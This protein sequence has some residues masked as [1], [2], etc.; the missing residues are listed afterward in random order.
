MEGREGTRRA[1]VLIDGEHHPSAVADALRLVERDFSIVALTFCGGGEKVPASVL[2]D[3]AAH[4]GYEL[5]RGENPSSA[6]A[7]AIASADADCVV[8]L[9][10]EP[11]VTADVKL[12]LAS[13]AEAAGLEYLAPGMG[14]PSAPTESV[15]FDGAQIAVIGTGKRTGKTAVCGHL[16]RVIDDAGGAPAVVS[17]GR[18]GPPAPIVE[19]PPVG[20]T[21]LLELSRG[22]VH[23]ASDYLE[24]AV[25]AGVPTVGCRRVGGGPG[26]E[27]ALTNF[28]DGALIAA[29]L[30]GIRTL[31][32][33]GSGA[34][35]PPARAGRT[36]C[37]VG[38]GDQGSETGGPLRIERGDLVLA[39]AGDARAI[40]AARAHAR[41]AV[42]EF[43]MAPEPI[44][45][46]PAAARV[47]VFTTRAGAPAGIDPVLTS[48]ALARREELARDLQEAFDRGCDYVL[49]ELKAAAIDT[50][51]EAAMA[52]GAGVG[53]IRNR[54]FAAGHDVEADLDEI[55]FNIWQEAAL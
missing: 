33:E 51:A 41:S 49:T 53:F 14:L 31:L 3:P 52:A 34:V 45:R 24:D 37:V 40:A 13:E 28:V 25:V 47:A 18:G 7:A 11:L 42:I 15:E 12:L 55:L 20:L 30:P 16:A 26:G 5:V 6:L 22:G 35:I 4:Y 43:A 48:T 19:L 39:P 21:K 10:D 27:T 44:E 29:R 32:Y 17:M 2:A 8:D 46:V 50:V 54:P 9:A 1:I 36:I 38:P 23:A